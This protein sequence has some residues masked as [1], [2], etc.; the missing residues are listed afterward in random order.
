LVAHRLF[1]VRHT[2]G[3][4]IAKLEGSIKKLDE[5]T[6][7]VKSQSGNDKEYDV[8]STEIGFKCS[9]PDHSF[10]GVRCK[11]IIACEISFT[12][13]KT[14]EQSRVVIEP[15]NIQN[16]PRCKSENII[17]RGIR[18][19]KLQDIQQHFCNDCGKWFVI[20]LG[21]ERMYATPKMITS[22]MQLY[23]SGESLRNVQKFFKLQGVKISHVAIY[24]WI[25]KYVTLM[26]G[27]L[28]QITPKVG[29]VWRSDELYVKI[30][31]NN[32]YLFALMDDETRF[33][34]AQQISER[35]NTSDISPLFKKGKDIAQKRPNVLITDGAPNFNVAFKNEFFTVSN[36]RTKHI[37]HVAD[38]VIYL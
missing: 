4:S 23:F 28:K 9:C 37:R 1:D 12:L 22:A 33:W 34:I 10:R 36:P 7:K 6:Y 31:G 18:R 19:N 17:K 30:K 38:I 13:H 11:H 5:H 20:N 3:E 35:K 32:K 15:I 16:C 21:F 29:D 2:K 24:K 14:V 26:Q 25:G 27:Y 8:V